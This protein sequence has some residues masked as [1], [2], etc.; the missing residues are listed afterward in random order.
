MVAGDRKPYLVAL[1][2]M[3]DLALSKEGIEDEKTLR[4]AIRKP[5]EKPPQQPLKKKKKTFGFL[6]RLVSRM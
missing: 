6:L 3:D 5:D 2:S 1:F 4:A